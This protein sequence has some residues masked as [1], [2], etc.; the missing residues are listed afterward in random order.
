MGKSGKGGGGLVDLMT[1]TTQHELF[2]AMLFFVLTVLL[3]CRSDRR[4]LS[5]ANI[6]L[7]FLLVGID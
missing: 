1:L 4:V 6:S 3:D 2:Q 5:K 7:A